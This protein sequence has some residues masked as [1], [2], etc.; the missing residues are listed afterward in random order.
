M[1]TGSNLRAA[2]LLTAL[3]LSTAC[4]AAGGSVGGR[5]DGTSWVLITYAETAPLPGTAITA[6]FEDGRISGSSGCNSYS[7]AYKS[8][9]DEIEIGDLAWTLM[10]C[11]EPEGVMDQERLIMSFLGDARAYRLAEGQ[12]Q[13]FRSDGEAMTFIPQE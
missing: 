4:T 8:N 13:I 6:S 11:V 12:L 5:L 9:G 1:R 3:L 2:I 7:G 10:A